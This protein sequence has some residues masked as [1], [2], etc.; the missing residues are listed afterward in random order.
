MA[1][2]K[3]EDLLR[4]PHLSKGEWRRVYGGNMAQRIN[5][6]PHS[7][8]MSE[9]FSIQKTSVGQMNSDYAGWGGKLAQNS[10]IAQAH[11]DYIAEMNVAMQGSSSPSAIVTVSKGTMKS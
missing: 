3:I 5:T 10:E 11:G 6:M 2:I 4:V 9:L 7:T 8:V 1:R